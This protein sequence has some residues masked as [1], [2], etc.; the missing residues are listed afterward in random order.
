MAD[1]L[2]TNVSYD[3][4]TVSIEY[5]VIHSDRRD[6]PLLVFL[7]EGL[8]SV[9]MWKDWPANLCQLLDCR[10]LVFSRYGYG[11]ST[12]RPAQEQWA[13]DFMHIQAQQFLPAFFSA[14][15][16]DTR[17]DQPILIGHSDGAS[18][19]LLYA[20]AFPEQV[21]ATAVLAPH[22]FVEDATVK[23]IALA[24][25]AYLTTDLPEKLQRYHDDVDSAF[26]GWNDVWLSAAFQ[27]WNIED[28]VADI[29]SPIL[30][31]QGR[32]DEYGS[33]A[34]IEHIAQLA[35]NVELY[36]IDDCRHSPHRDKPEQTS[37]AIVAFVRALL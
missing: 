29:R 31:I 6:R 11:K 25:Q 26:W 24:R 20:A 34:Q 28:E 4:K 35:A 2:L 10:G 14:L 37:D 27:T 32:E 8:G 19:A 23:N 33:L 36:V 18:I 13:T 22:L 17:T 9:A 21:R 1:T 30:A 15:G 12:P 16:I 3:E 7:H 5:Q